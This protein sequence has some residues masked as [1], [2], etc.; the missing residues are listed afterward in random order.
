MMLGFRAKSAAVEATLPPAGRLPA[1]V[2]AGSRVYAVGDI[3][4]R[5]DLLVTLHRK[6][7]DD[8][9]AHGAARNVVV[10]LGDYIDRGSEARRV[11]DILLDEPLANFES[12]HLMGNHEAFLLGFLDDPGLGAGWLINGGGETLASYGVAAPGGIGAAESPIDLHARTVA[13]LPAAHRDFFESLELSHEEGDY[14]FVH[15]GVRPDIALEDQDPEDLLWIREDFLDSPVDHGKTIVHGHTITWKP[16]FR[17]NRIGI[18]TGAF[19]S[20]V[21]TALV[22]SGST[23]ALL[24]S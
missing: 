10:Y 19:T 6:I 18:D 23:Q 2:P 9:A 13:A 11:V 8:A 14:F 5:A 20:D 12:V 21:L 1:A 15:A 7:A 16:E 24:Q 22:L 3:H 17:D 4:G